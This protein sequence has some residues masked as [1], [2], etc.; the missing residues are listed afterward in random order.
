MPSSL[1]QALPESTKSKLQRIDFLGIITLTATIFLLLFL[2]Q[3]VDFDT[4]DQSPLFYLLGGLFVGVG[5]IFL[6]IEMYWAQHPLIPLDMVE[7]ACGGY[8]LAQAFLAVGRSAVSPL[9]VL[10]SRGID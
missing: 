9:P 6:L 2:L 10:W 4:I 3:S 1:N 7:K 5:S 8:C